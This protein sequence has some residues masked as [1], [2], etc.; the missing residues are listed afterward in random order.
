MSCN[1]DKAL[2]DALQR[3]LQIRLRE[4]QQFAERRRAQWNAPQGYGSRPPS[5]VQQVADVGRD[6]ALDQV[7]A[8]LQQIL[9][10]VFP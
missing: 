2:Q 3:Q 6:Y 5:L 1:A 9:A 8:G 10:T 4:I 7:R